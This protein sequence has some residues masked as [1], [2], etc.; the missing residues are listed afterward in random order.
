MC[1]L[2]LCSWCRD[3]REASGRWSMRGGKQER[4]REREAA[5]CV[6]IG[7]WSNESFILGT[8]S[9]RLNE[10]RSEAVW[11]GGKG[12]KTTGATTKLYISKGVK[13]IFK[14]LKPAGESGRYPVHFQQ[15]AGFPLRVSKVGVREAG[16]EAQEAP[17]EAASFLRHVIVVVLREIL[18]LR[19]ILVLLLL[20]VVVSW[21]RWTDMRLDKWNESL[22]ED[23]GEGD[24]NPC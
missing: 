7:N 10:W 6:Q 9:K 20:R 3:P 15:H 2:L 12:W 1:L 17:L 22:G 23:P 24:G 5:A 11:E 14:I 4:L 13:T 18:S 19:A 16:A 21:R 8:D